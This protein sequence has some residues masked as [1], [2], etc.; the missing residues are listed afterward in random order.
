MGLCLF[1]LKKS[2]DARN[3]LKTVVKI[4]Y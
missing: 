1:I 2:S 4:D 3:Y